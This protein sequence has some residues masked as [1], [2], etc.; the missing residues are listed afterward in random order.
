MRN[1]FINRLIKLAEIDERIVLLTAD[2]GFSVLEE[3]ADRF[4]DR[5][6]NVGV[7]EQNMVGVATGL[8]ESG[9]IPF[10]YSIAP[11]SLLRPYEFI[12]N[13]PIAHNLPVRIVAIGSGFE[14]GNLGSSHHLIEDI[15]LTRLFPNLSIYS[16]INE[17]NAKILLEK[18]YKE[19][20]PIYYRIGKNKTSLSDNI[21]CIETNNLI[22][23]STGQEPVCLFGI[24][25]IIEEIIQATNH[26]K[27]EGKLI[28]SYAITGINKDLEQQLLEI[29]PSYSFVI[30]VEE[31][32]INGGIG[33]MIAEIIAENQLTVK[34]CRLGVKTASD[35]ICGNT[36][37]M[38][39]KYNIDCNAIIKKIFIAL[40]AL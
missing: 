3:F 39:Q 38:H 15:A 35:G 20:N 33:S 30:S 13:G 21:D 12:R 23:L 14:Y 25:S 22:Q 8:A 32:Y 31:H 19:N 11:F 16:P 40:K 34:L 9:F 1:C 37:F 7:S 24:G 6:Y 10:T 28:T 2:L 26:L 27:Q 36:S 4:P 5:F 17:K 29:I 18:T